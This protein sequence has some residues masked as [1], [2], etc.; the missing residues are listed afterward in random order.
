MKIL[1]LDNVNSLGKPG[2]VLEVSPGYARNYLLPR[3]LAVVATEVEIKGQQ[4]RLLKIKE[5]LEKKMG[6]VNEKLVA[7]E[8]KSISIKKK[9]TDE[10]NLFGSVTVKEIKQAL[11]EMGFELKDY[12]VDLD[13]VEKK[14]GEYKIVLELPNDY[15][16]EMDLVVEKL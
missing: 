14:I 1:L 3:G 15:Q 16:H 12:E 5:N 8:G 7:L 6:Q 10:G 4:E 13:T 9:A 11:K 2:D